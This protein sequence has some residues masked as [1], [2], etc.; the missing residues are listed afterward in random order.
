MAQK[1]E[2]QN[3]KRFGQYF[4][5]IEKLKTEL[6]YKVFTLSSILLIKESSINAQYFL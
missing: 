5:A 3:R 4:G 1:R 2:N 6:N